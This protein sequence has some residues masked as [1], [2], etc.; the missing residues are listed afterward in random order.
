MD[1][2][3]SFS[4]ISSAVCVH[5]G[6]S[7][8]L[9]WDQIQLKEGRRSLLREPWG[10]EGTVSLSLYRSWQGRGHFCDSGRPAVFN[11]LRDSPNS[12][13]EFA[14]LV[15]SIWTINGLNLFPCH[16]IHPAL[17]AMTSDLDSQTFQTPRN[18]GLST[19]VCLSPAGMLQLPGPYPLHL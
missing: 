18:L 2:W 10:W 8:S 13:V 6:L 19:Y 1:V 9:L 7:W 3:L 12:R 17:D 15:T 14:C 11:W 4:S 5:Q 16:L